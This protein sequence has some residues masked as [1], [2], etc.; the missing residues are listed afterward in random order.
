VLPGGFH[1]AV[2]ALFLAA[3]VSGVFFRIRF[4]SANRPRLKRNVSAFATPLEEVEALMEDK[5]EEESSF[6][7]IFGRGEGMPELNGGTRLVY[8]NTSSSTVF[9]TTMLGLIFVC[10]AILV[11][12]GMVVDTANGFGT[13]GVL[14]LLA[15]IFSGLFF[16][17]AGMKRV[18]PYSRV[19]G[20]L[21]MAPSL[22]CI[23]RLIGNFLDLSQNSNEYSHVLQIA[24]LCFLTLF[25]FNEG[26]FTLRASTYY[27]FGLYI[28]SAA[29]SL[30]AIAAV[31][32]PNLLLASFWMVHFDTAVFN[33]LLEF[34]VG[35]YIIT[36][37]FSVSRKL[38]R[39]SE[40]D[41]VPEKGK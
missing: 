3:M 13:V 34:T 30:I 24:C 10:S 15:A 38:E 11:F 12:T 17:L 33:S 20:F 36:R 6:D 1:Y 19:F 18:Y 22:W 27:N 8:E 26:K 40:G 29:A 28:A 4:A 7:R 41:L 16:L 37:L 39:L 31:S 2:Y 14:T 25:F 5:K 21:S 32:V 35:I 9:S 23:F